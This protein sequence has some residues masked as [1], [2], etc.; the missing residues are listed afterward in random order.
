MPSCVML[1][2]Y[3]TNKCIWPGTDI[4]LECMYGT[5]DYDAAQYDTLWQL[6]KS[7]E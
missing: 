5:M 4:D 7:S 2:Q 1:N 6:S 3:K